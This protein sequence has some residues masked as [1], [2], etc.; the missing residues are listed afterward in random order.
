MTE[1]G[2]ALLGE[3]LAPESA[4]L[5]AAMASGESAAALSAA[6]DLLGSHAAALALGRVEGLARA[7]HIGGCDAAA[8]LGMGPPRAGA[9]LIDQRHALAQVCRWTYEAS[10]ATGKR[11]DDFLAQANRAAG[12]V[13][14]WAFELD[15]VRR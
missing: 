12:P 4:K 15:G 14:D 10:T 1:A 9:W 8:E 7:Q 6:G 11:R 13:V 5:A 3:G 2:A